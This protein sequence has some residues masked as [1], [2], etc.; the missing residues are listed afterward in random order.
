[1]TH[2]LISALARLELLLQ[3]ALIFARTRA[4][5]AAK[6]SRRELHFRLVTAG[7]SF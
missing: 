5:V 2:A 4:V 3:R 6:P 7:K 1:M